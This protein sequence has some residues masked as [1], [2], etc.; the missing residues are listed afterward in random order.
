MPL[1]VAPVSVTG[2]GAR[3]ADG[4]RADW[5][6]GAMHARQHELGSDRW[7]RFPSAGVAGLTL[8]TI[9]TASW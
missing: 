5:T 6:G 9:S 1:T 2:V 3:I 8:R 7:A 4:D